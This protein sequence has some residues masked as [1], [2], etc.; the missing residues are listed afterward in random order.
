MVRNI[1]TD[2]QGDA[3][4]L[5]PWLQPHAHAGLHQHRG[6]QHQDLGH[7]C[8]SVLPFPHHSTPPRGLWSEILWISILPMKL[9]WMVST[10]SWKSQIRNSGQHPPP[11]ICA[12]FLPWFFQDCSTPPSFPPCLFAVF[13]GACL[14]LWESVS[15]PVVSIATDT[16]PSLLPRRPSDGDWG[17][18]PNTLN[19]PAPAQHNRP[20]ILSFLPS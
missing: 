17:G 15:V 14:F 12:K 2:D 18:K 20:A 5:A 16:P 4:V 8:H 3:S 1:I 10:P 19:S 13:V 11:Y 9:F 7:H 6:H